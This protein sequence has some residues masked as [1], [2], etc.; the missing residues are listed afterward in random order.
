MIRA[1]SGPKTR[2]QA[3]PSYSI[4]RGTPGGKRRF[5]DLI[6]CG[7]RADLRFDRAI[8]AGLP[9]AKGAESHGRRGVVGG[10]QFGELVVAVRLFRCHHRRRALSLSHRLVAGFE[11]RASAHDLD[12]DGPMAHRQF[13]RR[14]ARQLLD[15]HGQGRLL[16][17]DRRCRGERRHGDPVL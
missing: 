15:L 2:L 7:R 8:N 16:H 10:R 14:L 6:W 4:E 11:D 3:L 5:P 1:P 9:A 17:R 12:D 13:R